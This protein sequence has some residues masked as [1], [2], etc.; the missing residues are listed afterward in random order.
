MTTLKRR[1]F[2]DDLAPTLT[3]R[4]KIPP[5]PPSLA[6]EL[7]ISIICLG[8]EEMMR[9]I[10][11]IPA[12]ENRFAPMVLPRWQPDHEFHKL[13]A[14]FETI[15]PLKYPS[16]LQS[17]T[18]A[19]KL[20]NRSERLVNSRCFSLPRPGM[21]CALERSGSPKRLSTAATTC[22]I[23]S[24][25]AARFW[26]MWLSFDLRAFKH[27]LDLPPNARFQ[28]CDINQFTMRRSPPSISRHLILGQ[29][30]TPDRAH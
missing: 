7:R 1:S 22:R 21:R 12:V 30:P 27:L 26:L 20:L 28:H 10:R 25:T 24:K 8:T 29:P 14:S 15:I 2:P 9:V 23:R 13:L 17:S 6:N 4:G 18:M 11:S 5:A 3:P 16:D 19:T